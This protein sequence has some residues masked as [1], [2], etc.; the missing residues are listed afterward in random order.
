MSLTRR[1]F[2]SLP[3][4]ESLADRPEQNAV[5]WGIVEK[6]AKLGYVPEIFRD[7]R[8]GTVGEVAATG[9]S[10]DNFDDVIRR[11]VGC[12]IIGLPRWHFSDGS[13]QIQLASEFCHYE[14]AIASSLKLPLLVIRQEG[15]LRRVFFDQSYTGHAAVLPASADR[16]WLKTAAFRRPFAHWQKEL[17]KRCDVFFGYCGSSVETAQALKQYLVKELG[18]T[19]VDW[20]TDF[21][22]A[23]TIFSEIRTAAD[24]CSAGVFLFTRDD[25]FAKRSIS[26]PR[27]NVVFEAGY[28]SS[29][30]G[31]ERVLIIREKGAKMPS[32][33]GGDIYLPLADPSDIA[34]LRD[35]VG[36]F[37]DAL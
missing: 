6:I 34:L 36:R 4:D 12:V 14:G 19:V 26:A 11:C 20:K 35:M 25:R 23:R 33:L 24:R 15:I 7:S 28:F 22:P 29:A 37:I 30:K 32:D 27:D 13:K 5:K 3:S 2:V 16:S 10:A 8:E 17:G 31:K 9:W 1:I 18:V 21:T